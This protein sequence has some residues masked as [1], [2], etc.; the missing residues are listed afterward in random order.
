MDE[1]YILIQTTVFLVTSQPKGILPG[2]LLSRNS[3]IKRLIQLIDN[4]ENPLI[5][6]YKHSF[7]LKVPVF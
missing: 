7:R 1:I 3:L 5:H 2:F 6:S 4:Q